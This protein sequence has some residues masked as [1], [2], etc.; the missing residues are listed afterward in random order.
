MFEIRSARQSDFPAIRSLVRLVK[1]NPMNLDWRRFVVA[2]T[3]EGV[4][5]GC[6]QIKPHGEGSMELASIAVA[7]DWRHQGVASAIINRLL[8]EHPSRLYLTCRANLE[9]F[10]ARFGF[11]TIAPQA[12]PGYFRRISLLFSVIYRLN[13]IDERLLVMVRDESKPLRG[14]NGHE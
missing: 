14:G 6:G 7:P 5:I 10:Y 2:I 12:M 8:T 4:L 9:A 3:S 13:L 11:R 1:I